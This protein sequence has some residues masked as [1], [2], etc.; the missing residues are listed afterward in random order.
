[1]D[2]E[3]ILFKPIPTSFA[4]VILPLAVPKPY[5][6]SIP[7]ELLDRV[8]FGV[9]VE[10]Q[11]SQAKLY[12]AIVIEITTT[13]PDYETKPILNV[14]DETPIITTTQLDLWKW[15]S[16]YYAC[17]LGEVMIAALPNN[18]KLSSETTIVLNPDH[19]LD[20][21]DLDDK[22]YLVAEALTIQSELSIEDIRKILNQKTVYPI[23]NRLLMRDILYLKEELTQKYKP[24][25]VNCVQLA[26]DMDMKQAF[27]KVA[28]SEK[29]NHALLAF[30]Q[31]QKGKAKPPSG[32]TSIKNITH[33]R[34]SEIYETA[35]VDS[36]V[37]RAMEKKGIFIIFEIEISR[38]GAYTHEVFADESLSQQ[39]ALAISSIEKQFETQSTI[40]VHGVTGSGKTRVYTE[41]IQKTIEQGGQILYLLPEIGLTSQ[42]SRR[43]QKIFGD[44]IRVYHSKFSNAEQVELWH[45]VFNG[46]PIILG[47]RSALFLPFRSLQLIIVD[48]EHD[49]SFKQTDPNPRYQA[50]DCAILLAKLSKAKVILGSATP[51]LESFHNAQTHKYGFV[52]MKERYGGVKMPEI[53]VVDLKK[54]YKNKTMQSNFSSI[55]IAEI[56]EALDR[57][58]QIILF[59]NR[60]GY[61]PTIQCPT[62]AWTGQCRHCDVTLTYHKFSNSLNCHYC[63]YHIRLPKECPACGAQT[64]NIKGY[65]TER[66]EDELE[67][68]LPDIKIGRMDLDNVRTKNAHAQIINDFEEKRI[69]IL[70]GTQM[71]TKGLDFDNV[72]LVGV[73]SAD[74][75]WQFPD[76]RATER[77]FQ[78]MMQ[79][80]GRAGRKHKQGKVIIQ[81]FDTTHPVLREV[82]KNDYSAFYTRELDERGKF[83][84]PPY[85]RTI[86]I[87]LKHKDV[88]VL[89]HASK[90]FTKALVAKLSTAAQGPALPIVPRVS[91]YFMLDYLLKLENNPTQLR[92]AKDAITAATYAMQHS[93]GFSNVRVGVDV[94]NN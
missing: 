50:R 52:E 51:S 1:M 30:L 3:N 77:A 58:E 43:L 37:I 15:I 70:V 85:I 81:A 17:T 20:F 66:I 93:E 32:A 27:E 11:L 91:N 92:Y 89:N 68:I 49:A 86:K 4:T 5:T 7:D 53:V 35:G 67:I 69:D 18:L 94:D 2:K 47:A 87:T 8:Q 64:L 24:K 55:L 23:I 41:L 61:S 40:L 83:L 22:E 10:V 79:V 13:K 76:F 38:I 36:A 59:Q 78:L 56:K 57:K 88:E 45:Q 31:I 62:C 33:V 65:G 71:V 73:L 82:I 63:G 16:T 72:G 12:A 26:P 14:I 25:M 21:Q 9:R 46:K 6:Y 54:E 34:T 75:L 39:Q 19:N 48:E 44:S 90:I 80:A 42:S 84:F 28:K 29:Q 60:R 74:N